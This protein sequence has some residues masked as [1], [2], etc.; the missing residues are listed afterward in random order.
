MIE[1]SWLE[2]VNFKDIN[3]KESSAYM[4]KAQSQVVVQTASL[5]NSKGNLNQSTILSAWIFSTKWKLLNEE[6]KTQ[7]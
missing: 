2:N 6:V 1:N 4:S 7:E 3:C 5:L